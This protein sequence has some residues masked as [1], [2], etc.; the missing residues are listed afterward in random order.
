[1]PRAEK[2]SVEEIT[3]VAE[4]A[5]QGGVKRVRLTGGEPLVHPHEGQGE[6]DLVIFIT[7][8]SLSDLLHSQRIPVRGAGATTR[9]TKKDSHEKKHSAA[10]SPSTGLLLC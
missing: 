2:L 4:T 10:D 5:A 9:P 1:M 3:C 6:G 7:G 8:H